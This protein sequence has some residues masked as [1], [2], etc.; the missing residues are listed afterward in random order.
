LAKNQEKVVPPKTTNGSPNFD[1]MSIIQN[2]D[3]IKGFMTESQLQKLE[4]HASFFDDRN[5]I[6]FSILDVTDN[7]VTIGVKQQAAPKVFLAAERELVKVAKSL[8]GFYLDGFQ[9][10]IKVG[11]YAELM[12]ALAVAPPVPKEK[13]TNETKPSRYPDGKGIIENSH[14]IEQFI[15]EEK[16]RRMEKHALFFAERSNIHF[17]VCEVT[18]PDI[19]VSVEQREVKVGA[20][21]RPR[22]LETICKSFFEFYL[23]DMRIHL[24]S[25]QFSS[26][27]KLSRSAEWY[28]NEIAARGITVEQISDETGLSVLT[29]RAWLDGKQGMSTLAKAMFHYMLK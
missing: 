2:I 29:L 5:R 11:E 26:L 7:L 25:R 20:A 9:L 17:K 4:K 24:Q 16:L 8:F 6:R 21:I 18:D 10:D 15:S 12:R 22:E 13:P 14:L 27:K 23:D 3:L 1:T 19:L 28:R